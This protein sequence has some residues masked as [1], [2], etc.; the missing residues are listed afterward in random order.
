[1][2]YHNSKQQVDVA[3][4]DFSK[5]FDVVPH[6]RLLG[7]LR[8]YGIDGPVWFW[9]QEFLSSRSQ[10]TVVDG[11]CSSWTSV[12]SG[13]PQGT[14]LGPLLFLLHINDLPDCVTS[15]V[16]LFADDCLVYRV[17]NSVQDQLDL[18]K[19]LVSLAA[20][21]DRW[22]MSFNPSKCNIITIARSSSPLHKFYSLCGEVLQHVSE[23][24]Y[25]GVL[26]SDDLQWSK[27][28]QHTTARANS[29]L[30][31]LRRNLH[32][33]PEKL[34]ELAY[35]ALIRS[36][37]DYCA[38]VWDPH[39]TKDQNSLETIQR[40]AARF[41]KK[42]YARQS[43]VTQML[44]DLEWQPLKDRRRD[45]RLTL[46]FRMVHGKVAVPV[47]DILEKAD[48]RTRSQHSYKY[49]HLTA[50]T[51]QFKN[52]FFV[53]TIPKWNALPALAVNADTVPAF[54]AQLRALP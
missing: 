6:Q 50:N 36:R 21:A 15:Q 24:K 43:S 40:R 7:K 53:A 26:L 52:S 18:Q 31:L 17:I 23:A 5:A 25:L 47:E 38:A 41:T 45:I 42:D 2:T 44:K 3:V 19:D 37:L 27:H 33:C 10:C 16:R 54:K 11:D 20:W 9:I 51:E 46:L 8:H 35:I 34:R 30:G 48:S 14:V 49:K 28:I 39:L 22:G 13:V 32:H 1:M 29:T 4:L 12:D